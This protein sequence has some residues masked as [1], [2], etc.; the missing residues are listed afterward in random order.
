MHQTTERRL[1]HEIDVFAKLRQDAP[2]RLLE[3]LDQALVFF[4]EEFRYRL[5]QVIDTLPEEGDNM[6]KILEVVRAQWKDIQS[7]RLVQIAVTGPSQT[8][9]T[10]LLGAILQKKARD[11]DPIFTVVETPGL[12]EFL[13]Y[14]SDRTP[15]EMAEADL[16]VL[17]LDARYG[18][19]DLTQ[20]ILEKLRELDKPILVV[21]NKIDLVDNAG[22]RVK[23]AKSVLR[24][25]VFSTS[26]Y[27]PS[28]LDNLLKAMVTACPKALYPLAQ[29]F[30]EFRSTLCRGIITQAAFAV[31][32]VGIVPI[33]VSDLL[34]NAAIQTAMILRI[35]RAFGC[36]LNRDRARE[37]LPML[38]AGILARQMGH[39]LRQKYPR[40]KKLI[41]VM[42]GGSFTYLMGRLAVRYFESTREVLRTGNLAPWEP[43][44]NA[45]G[46][47]SP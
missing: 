7:E 36:E 22:D 39:K 5:K 16:I 21:L 44:P 18:V 4:P 10:S 43:L 26:V 12:E 25:S 40:Q 14:G 6:Q 33:P 45:P 23:E 2:P 37:L 32:L 9:K 34:P 30:P 3:F 8:G 35:A 42:L 1:P 38:T 24:S 19:S 31:G 41:G 15:P 17:V 29:S 11:A 28:T 20:Q 27:D 13:G 47:T 46:E